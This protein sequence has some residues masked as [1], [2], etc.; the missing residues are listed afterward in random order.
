MDKRMLKY[1]LKFIAQGCLFYILCI[2]VSL[3]A[4]VRKSMSV[5]LKIGKEN[6][7]GPISLVL[8]RVWPT[9]VKLDTI[10]LAGASEVVTIRD[11]LPA[12]YSLFSKKPLLSLNILADANGVDI[13][14]TPEGAICEGSLYDNEYKEYLLK[15][16]EANTRG[17]IIGNAYLKEKDLDKKIALN[18]ESNKIYSKWMGDVLEYI[19][20]NTDNVKGLWETHRHI[21]LFPKSSLVVL[22]EAFRDKPGARTTFQELSGALARQTETLTIGSKAPTF[23]L[24]SQS[25][26]IIKLDS[27]LKSK[28]FLLIDFWASWC[29]PC[30]ATNRRL[31]PLYNKLNARGIDLASI[32]VDS[33]EVDWQKAVASDKLPWTQLIAPE[34][35]KSA[36]VKQYGV[37]SLPTTFLID[38]KGVIVKMHLS[39][40]E[41]SKLLQE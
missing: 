18:E 29:T 31:V 39:E 4:Q 3:Q 23:S 30:R 17:R 5:T 33:K 26:K 9:H 41:I 10:H 28:R 34:A 16:R 1:T 24:K 20:K 7:D 6:I 38:N 13:K 22:S 14:I 36:I 8:S 32:S 11:S 40:D 21:R 35:M 12:V 25:G 15:E 2:P 27:L 37:V 19:L